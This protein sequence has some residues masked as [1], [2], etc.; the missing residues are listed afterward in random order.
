MRSWFTFLNHFLINRGKPDLEIWANVACA[1]TFLTHVCF[2]GSWRINFHVHVA[3]AAADVFLIPKSP[4][5]TSFLNLLKETERRRRIELAS[6]VPW[7]WAALPWN[8]L[9]HMNERAKTVLHTTLPGTEW[10]VFIS[11][12]PSISMLKS[13]GWQESNE[14]RQ[15]LRSK[16]VSFLPH[17]F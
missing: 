5:I 7:K 6:L 17:H 8:D 11:Y 2:A 12:L 9:E 1:R 10:L 4:V 13:S 16:W 14:D 15:I 3:A